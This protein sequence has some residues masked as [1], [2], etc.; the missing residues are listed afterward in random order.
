MC[1]VPENAY[2]IFSSVCV[3]EYR[4]TSRAH[5]VQDIEAVGLRKE[6]ERPDA[7]EKIPGDPA[8]ASLFREPLAEGAGMRLDCATFF[9]RLLISL[10]VYATSQACEAF[11]FL[12]G[13]HWKAKRWVKGAM[14]GCCRP[15]AVICESAGHLP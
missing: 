7:W 8:R 9:F 14:R 6:A 13:L 1:S 15:V 11:F 4:A 2:Q 3:R 5:L 12:F 10:C